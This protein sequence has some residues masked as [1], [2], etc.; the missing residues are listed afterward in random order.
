D[1]HSLSFSVT[2]CYGD[3]QDAL[4]CE[5]YAQKDV[6]L[7]PGKPVRLPVKLVNAKGEV[8]FDGIFDGS[9]AETLKG[10]MNKGPGRSENDKEVM[11]DVSVNLA[12]VSQPMMKLT[13][14]QD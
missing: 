7:A 1:S 13:P 4:P 14:V 9:K 8:F 3:Y 6:R 2:T 12:C 5:E 10:K 11:G